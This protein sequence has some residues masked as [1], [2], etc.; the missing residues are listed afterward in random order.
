MKTYTLQWTLLT[1]VLGLGLAGQAQAKP[2]AGGVFC[3][4]Y[5]T[6]PECVGK[7]PSC[8]YC[9]IAPPQRNVFGTM[10]EKSLALGMPRPLSDADFST[11]LPSALTAVEAQDADGD[12]V[13]NLEEIQRGTQPADPSSKPGSNACQGGDNP[14]YSVCRYDLRHAYKKVLRDLCGVSPSFADVN[15][16]VSKASDDERRAF[17]D[18]EIDR[19]AQTEFW[20]GKNGQLWKVAHPKI[21][22]VGSLKDGEDKGGVP[23][24]DYYDDY[25][26]FAYTQTDDHD[27]RE[28][29]TADFFVRRDVNPT[30]YSK[31]ASLTSQKVD[32][33]HRAGNMTTAW[34][35]TDFIMFTAIPRNAASQMY[36]AYLGLDIAKQEGLYS[37]ANEPQDYDA[38]GVTAKECAA[39]HATLDPLTYPFRNYNGIASSKY[40]TQYIP[41]RLEMFFPTAAPRIT[42]TPEKGVIFGKPVNNLREWAQVAVDSDAFAISATKD[43]WKLLVGHAPTPEENAEFVATWQRFKSTHQFRVQKL[44]HDIVKTEAYGA[45]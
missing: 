9:H 2:P 34:S 8:T 38:K 10:L 37:V 36:R 40:E 5:P 41:N 29:L 4:K 16:F 31:V 44:L 35:L 15:A 27:A 20:R 32:Q 24:A 21:R 7:Q 12:G 6:S 1:T 25:N 30:R 3:Q 11:A 22:P 14:Q 13:S 26:L 45:P 43:Y 19:C 39:C 33:A 17:I 42:Q 28:V 23:L 18:A